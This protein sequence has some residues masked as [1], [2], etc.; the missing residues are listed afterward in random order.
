MRS[1][2][3]VN[4]TISV[5]STI[6]LAPLEPD[7]ASDGSGRRDARRLRPAV[8]IPVSDVEA[9]AAVAESDRPHPTAQEAVA[10]G[11]PVRGADQPG[12]AARVPCQSAASRRPSGRSGATLSEPRPAL[13]SGCSGQGARVT[14]HSKAQRGREWPA[15]PASA[16]APRAAAG[17]GVP[18]GVAASSAQG[19]GAVLDGSLARRASGPCAPPRRWGRGT[20]N[21]RRSGAAGRAGG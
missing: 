15:I 16:V 9:G 10:L 20:F 17:A 2:L 12:G 7:P 4:Q 18:R 13:P 19:D 3:A 6:R 8:T 5:R 11:R 14:R 21:P 1:R